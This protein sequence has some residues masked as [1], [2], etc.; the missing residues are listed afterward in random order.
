MS[1]I[2]IVFGINNTGAKAHS[3]NSILLYGKIFYIVILCLSQF[4]HRMLYF[5]T[6]VLKNCVIWKKRRRSNKY[7][8]DRYIQNVLNLIMSISLIYLFIDIIIFIKP[9]VEWVYIS[10]NM[11]RLDRLGRLYTLG[12]ACSANML[13]GAWYVILADL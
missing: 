6:A 1:S 5:C 13:E 11:T 3:H 8:C 12:Q 9:Y 4:Y 10:D 7:E 2:F